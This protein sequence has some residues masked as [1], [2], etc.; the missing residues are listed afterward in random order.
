MPAASRSRSRLPRRADCCYGQTS[1]HG[2]RQINDTLARPLHRSDQFTH[3][4]VPGENQHWGTG[5]GFTGEVLEV[6]A[7]F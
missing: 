3:L 5:D 6:D 2:G 4:S 1:H 7:A